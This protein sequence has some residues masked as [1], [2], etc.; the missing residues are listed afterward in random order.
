MPEEAYRTSIIYRIKNKELPAARVIRYGKLGKDYD[1]EAEATIFGDFFEFRGGGRTGYFP[2]RN[3][4]PAGALFYGLY[5]GEDN[6][7]RL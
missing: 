7:L 1:I 5:Y 2:V 3:S 4:L 6:P